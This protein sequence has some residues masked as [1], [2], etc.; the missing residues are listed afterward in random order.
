MKRFF[1]ILSIAAVTFAACNK[2]NEEPG[3]KI[4]PAQLVDMTFEVSAKPTQAAGVQNPSTKT[5]IK[6]DGT[7]L[8]SVGDKVSVFYEVNG[9]TGSSESEALTAETSRRTAPLPLP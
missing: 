7:V 8:W 5:E 1:T 3:Q 2:E 9:K 4:D 6:E